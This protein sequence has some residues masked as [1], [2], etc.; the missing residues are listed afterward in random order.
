MRESLEYL[1]RR[2]EEHYRHELDLIYETLQLPDD[3]IHELRE[4]FATN[5]TY[6]GLKELVDN[7]RQRHPPVDS[8]PPKTKKPRR[9]WTKHCWHT[10]KV[11]QS[12]NRTEKC[13]Q[14]GC[15]ARRQVHKDA[16]QAWPMPS[17]THPTWNIEHEG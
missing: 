15:G 10:V 14:P 8:S 11:H 1:K 12:N 5:P 16:P 7:I 3:E 6:Q 17:C 13:C 2:L 4:W 9:L